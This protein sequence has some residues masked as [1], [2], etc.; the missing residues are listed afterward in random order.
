[1][2]GDNRVSDLVK[3]NEGGLIAA[4][5]GIPDLDIETST[6]PRAL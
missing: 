5:R 2:P 6:L 3:T 1:M 4:I